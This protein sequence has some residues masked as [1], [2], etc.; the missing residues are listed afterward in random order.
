MKD[1]RTAYVSQKIINRFYEKVADDVAN[2]IFDKAIR[3]K[4]FSKAEGDEKKSQ[5]LYIELMVEEM[6]L[7]EEA[8]LEAEQEKQLNEL[9]EIE[10]RKKD[11]EDRK[12]ARKQF[13]LR[14]SRGFFNLIKEPFLGF[15][16]L[17]I[18]LGRL[19]IYLVIIFVVIFVIIEIMG[20]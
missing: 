5:A 18:G 20:N 16:E 10:D 3:I 9:R 13:L 19:T 1:K 12:K 6:I 7:L 15:Y 17:L 2:N 8:K 11:I 4:A 14:I